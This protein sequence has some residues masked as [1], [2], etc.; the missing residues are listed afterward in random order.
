[1]FGFRRHRLARA[2]GP[3]VAVVALLGAAVGPAA[4][5]PASGSSA[6]DKVKAIVLFDTKPGKAARQAVERAGGMVRETLGLV[7]GLA[8]DLPRGQLK[9]LAKAD[10]VQ[11]VELDV[12]LKALDHAGSTGD[13]EYENAWGVEHIGAKAVHDAG[14]RG[15]GVKVA[16]IDT[17]IDYIHDDPDDNPYVVDPEFNSNYR[18]GYDWINNDADP[19]DDHGHGT[20]VAGSLAAEKNGYLVVGVAP[21][22]DLYALKILGANGEGDGSN[23]ILALQW[24]LDNNIDIVNMSLGTH[25]V[26]A[27]LEAAVARAADQGLLMV[28]A[29]GNTVT[30]QELLY[31]C[32]V[33]YPGAYP[34]VLS[35]TFTNGNDA[36]TGYSC[37]GPEVDFASPGDSIF[38]P[39]PVGSCAMC[40]P[41]GYAAASGTSMASPHLAGSVALLLS[42][43]LTDTGPAGLIDDV[44]NQL[45]AT[46]NQGWG[47][48][49]GFGGGTPIP[50]SDPRYADY[51]GCGV[52]D[53]DEA[54]LGLNPPPPPPTN[55]PPDAVADDLP[56]TE[57]IALDLAVLG[58][59]LDPDS[60]P[61]TVSSVTDPTHGTATINPNGTIHYVPDANYAGDDDFSYTVSDG[62]GGTDTAPVKVRVA[63][64]PDAPSAADD[65]AT[66]PEDTPIDVAVLAND[67]DADGD[68][69]TVSAV[70]AA[71]KGTPAIN[72]DGSVRFT[73]AVNAVGDASFEYTI[74][75]G[76]G[77]TD[78]ASVVVS[79]TPVNDPPVAV[80]DSASTAQDTP[81]TITVLDNDSDVEGSTLGVAGVSDPPHGT[82]VINANGTITYTP[83][84][85]Y[86]GSDAFGYTATDGLATSNVAT[87]SVTISAAPPP[88]P[89]N[90]FHVGDL[91]R[92]TVI[93]GKSWTARATIRIDSADHAPLSGAVVTGTWS[94]GAS[95][96]GTCTTATNGTCTI[97]KTKLSRTTV[98]S[99]TFTVT[100]V[101]RTGGTYT[102]A[103]NHDPDGDSNG[104]NWIVILR[105]S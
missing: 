10:H 50:P 37:T 52:I 51:F 18:G 62:R 90:P 36:L 60:D 78:T 46:A 85:G 25:E 22:V 84:A 21:A 19:M 93:S 86:S 56:G 40:S 53:A 82:A 65:A 12:R 4:A 13:H 66:T 100:G 87:V 34:D 77:G 6:T 92:S 43:G 30:F 33:A 91:D 81:A 47:V 73:P 83:D 16:V 69:I 8:V 74:S 11:K 14:F 70:G 15:Q 105:P 101:T 20:H 99:V 29:S 58:N 89:P 95:G 1:M 104:G 42:A 45:C 79:L 17:G 5:A 54:V 28:A 68:P 27:A 7:N 96:T 23:L 32:P 94:N 57:D 35:T 26:S 55:N 76:N 9:A 24:A 39:V 67:S 97:Q 41:Y 75:D 49:T 61:L 48:Q 59:D 63:A 2:I 64:V 72:P 103:D 3:A 71:I 98:A 102:P 38:S 31:G 80:A 44:R 88:P